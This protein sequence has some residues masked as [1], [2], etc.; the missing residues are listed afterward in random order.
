VNPP[1]KVFK[2]SPSDFAFLW[3]Q[4]KRCFY[5]KV[6]R[7]IR[8][9][10]MPMAGIFKKI[11]GLQM[12]FYEGRPTGE[13]AADLPPGVIRC[14]E[15]WVESEV[16][17]PEGRKSGAYVVG[18]ID[19]LIEFEDKSWGVLDF[20][21]TETRGEHLSKYGRQLNAYAFAL[22]RPAAAP[23]SLKG[24]A[25]KLS[26]ISK[27]GLLCMEPTA[28]AQPEAGRHVYEAAVKWIELPRDDGKFRG[29]VAEV[30]SVLEGPL[31]PPDPECD[32]CQ[33]LKT[34]GVQAKQAPAAPPSAA[35][36]VPARPPAEG[37]ASPCPTCG[38][39]MVQ[40]SGRYGPFLSCT[41]YPDCRGTRNPGKDRPAS[42][43]P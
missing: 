26:P 8:Q 40:K 35:P 9:P 25:L 22:E 1:E 11:E 31:P 4:C 36:A 30:L 17:R 6:T 7:G 21:T 15:K 10:S 33:Y 38:A 14:G 32:W 24:E 27:I 23:R 39:P 37:A 28:L 16:I 34:M 42:K 41:R 3:E 20:K 5:L 43:A 18:K 2:L 13:V 12:K 29:F 19:S